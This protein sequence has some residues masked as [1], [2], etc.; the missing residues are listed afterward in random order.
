MEQES[1]GIKGVFLHKKGSR[2][3][4]KLL[5]VVLF[6]FQKK[7]TVRHWGKN[8]EGGEGLSSGKKCRVFFW[9]VRTIQESEDC[10]RMTIYLGQDAPKINP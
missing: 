7:R 4:W 2:F 5:Y 10:S 8:M 3:L 9:Q 1:R 6:P